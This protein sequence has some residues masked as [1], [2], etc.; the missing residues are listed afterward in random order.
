M[1]DCI[2]H[3]V[4]CKILFWGCQFFFAFLL[5]NCSFHSCRESAQRAFHRTWSPSLSIMLPAIRLIRMF[6]SANDPS[7]GERKLVK[8]FF[9]KIILFGANGWNLCRAALADMALGSPPGGWLHAFGGDYS[10]RSALMQLDLMARIVVGYWASVRCGV[11][12]FAADGLICLSARSFC[13][14]PAR[15]CPIE[16]KK[17]GFV[18]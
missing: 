14:I 6:L 10:R 17:C 13:R 1:P 8:S 2:L 18:V 15:N 12:G 16:G 3:F 11:L 9:A 4:K 5:K 7:E